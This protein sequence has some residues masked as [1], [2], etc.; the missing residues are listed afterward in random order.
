MSS[1]TLLCFLKP[2]SKS[3]LCCI[4]SFFFLNK[5]SWNLALRLVGSE[6]EMGPNYTAVD[7]FPRT[8]PSFTCKN[9]KVSLP[10][11]TFIREVTGFRMYLLKT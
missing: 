4:V 5:L 10:V 2:L 3:L 7:C 8:Y 6:I 11:T 9:S 1:L